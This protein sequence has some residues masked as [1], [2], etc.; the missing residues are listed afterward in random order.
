MNY[1][2]DCKRVEIGGGFAPSTALIQPLYLT[3]TGG[4]AS[5]TSS[6]LI[7]TTLLLVV[8]EL[9]FQ[10]PV[11]SN[12]GNREYTFNINTGQLT[13]SASSPADQVIYVLYYPTPNSGNSQAVEPVTLAEAKTQL[14][15]T[16]NDDDVE[17]YQMIKRARAHVENYCNISIVTKRITTI[18]RI[19]CPWELPYGPVVAIEGVSNNTG[20]TGSGP[21]SYTTSDWDW[22]IDGDLF[23]AGGCGK[24]RVVYTAGMDVVP[25]DL[26]QGILLQVS[27]LYENR[28]KDATNLGVSQEVMNMVNPYRKLWI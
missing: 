25:D 14:R 2:I 3:L 15:V 22:S 17:I 9:D 12:P 21:V 27:F 8:R 4:Q 6:A 16:F 1:I 28:G 26:K 10:V 20:V 5:V 23:D 19:D 7:N 13:F 18:M 24:T 11:A